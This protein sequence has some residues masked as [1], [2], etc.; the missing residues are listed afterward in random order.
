MQFSQAVRIYHH[1]SYVGKVTKIIIGGPEQVQH[2]EKMGL[3]FIF[4]D[5]EF[6][7]GLVK[8]RA[9]KYLEEM[10]NILHMIWPEAEGF[11]ASSHN[12]TNPAVKLKQ[13]LLLS[14]K[15]YRIHFCTP[16]M[17]YNPMWM[18]AEDGEA[19]KIDDHK[20]AGKKVVLCVF[21]ALVEQEPAPFT[22]ETRVPDLLA[23]NKK[24]FPTFQ[25]RINLNPKSVRA[26]AIVLV[27]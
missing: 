9:T 4:D 2:L 13:A 7:A 20:A 21:P 17:T 22:A 14:P 8:H 12:W 18:Q 25:E 3:K 23:G 1:I 5:E 11:K 19:F 10:K 16:G 27:E 6:Q 15:D 26:R 24:F